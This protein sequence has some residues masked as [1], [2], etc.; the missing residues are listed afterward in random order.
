M[1]APP[2]SFLNPP[3]PSYHSDQIILI[4]G[5]EY[6]TAIQS[7]LT[8]I[9]EVVVRKRDGEK[10][11]R[12]RVAFIDCLQISASEL[13]LQGTHW[14]SIIQLWLKF[15]VHAVQVT[16]SILSPFTSHVQFKT[17]FCNVV[18]T[19]NFHFP[20]NN[21]AQQFC[22]VLPNWKANNLTCILHRETQW[23]TRP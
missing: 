19:E 10:W 7:C 17:P 18:G 14:C 2:R 22:S 8:R 11:F 12:T 5:L 15:Y 3:C 4:T 6:F 9:S 16:K 20:L 1:C 13:C 21:F 23:V